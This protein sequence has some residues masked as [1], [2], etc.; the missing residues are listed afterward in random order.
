MTSPGRTFGF[1]IGKPE[2]RGGRSKATPQRGQM[3]GAVSLVAGVA[4]VALE[5]VWSTPSIAEAGYRQ[6]VDG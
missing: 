6:V 4:K 1:L 5:P 2:E 3:E